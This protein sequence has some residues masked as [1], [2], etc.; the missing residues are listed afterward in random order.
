MHTV[1]VLVVGSGA[2]GLNAARELLRA[3]RGVVVLEARDRV[4]GRVFSPGGLD[5][6]P[7]WFWSNEP[8]IQKLIAVFGLE[9]FDQHLAGDALVQTAEGVQRLVGNQIDAPSGRVVG[10][11]QSLADALL[12]NIG[13]QHVRLGEQVLS[14]QRDGDAVIVQSMTQTW[15][16]QSV[17]L[18]V[19]PATAVAT[20][21]F[22]DTLDPTLL[23][24]ASSTPVWMGQ[25][26]K[27]VARYSETFWRARGLAGSAFSHV[28]P[29]R[30]LH[31]MSGPSGT[32]AAIF[33]FA[34]P[35]PDTAPPSPVDVITQL[36]EL[37]GPE[38]AEPSE[39]I[40]QDW[41]HER[42]TSPPRVESL[43]SYE[44]FGHPRYQEPALAGRLHWA[45]TETS[46]VTPGH[47]EGALAASERA[48]RYIVN[49]QH[50]KAT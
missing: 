6:G 35:Q 31:D 12:A 1:D 41:R 43:G 48:V 18:A 9:A 17:I 19:P 16:A 44:L 15:R 39:L 23:G 25:M 27:V 20:I 50:A 37:F 29:M 40:I 3:D 46:T 7:S 42:F 38:A 5:V 11:M 2:A 30:E 33:G 32:P 13:E 36:V 22:G 26:M 47:I 28:G 14:I 34:P 21:D 45:S 24:L 4:G 8:R 10:G 49:E